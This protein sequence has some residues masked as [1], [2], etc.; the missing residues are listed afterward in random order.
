MNGYYPKNFKKSAH[1]FLS[2]P[3][4]TDLL[5]NNDLD[6]LFS[7]LYASEDL[8]GLAGIAY[9]TELL[10]DNGFLVENYVTRTYSYQFRDIKR[11]TIYL[12]KC[13]QIQKYSFAHNKYLEEINAPNVLVA[14][15][16]AFKNCKNLHKVD[17]P[18][19]KEFA[20]TTFMGCELLIPENFT[21]PSDCEL[22]PIV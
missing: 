8:N 7:K 14:C 18:K 10:Y 5:R 4:Q 3:E 16:Y 13:K 12:P 22:K 9:V 19:L 21:V 17:L 6:T 15:S 1:E 20:E 11:K 2:Q